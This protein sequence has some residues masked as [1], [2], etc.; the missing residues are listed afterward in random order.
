[1]TPSEYSELLP[2][3]RSEWLDLP[4]V[5][6]PLAELQ[7]GTSSSALFPLEFAREGRGQR[8]TVRLVGC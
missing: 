7:I 8:R 4:G 2:R 3:Y 1:M 5:A 6:N